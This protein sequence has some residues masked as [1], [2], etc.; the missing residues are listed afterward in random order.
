M[1]TPAADTEQVAVG[2][3]TL[4]EGMAWRRTARVT[5]LA[6]SGSLMDSG[7]LWLSTHCSMLSTL[8]PCTIN[9]F[10]NS[11]YKQSRANGTF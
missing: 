9:Q 2:R 4:G 7:P 11:D 10:T 3:C 5:C 1:V 8:S 6:R